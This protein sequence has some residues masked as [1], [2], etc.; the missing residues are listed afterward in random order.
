MPQM[1]S[2][3]S[4]MMQGFF[5]ILNSFTETVKKYGDC[6]YY[7]DKIARWDKSKLATQWFD[8]ATPMSSGFIVM[9]H[10][11]I[12]LNNMMYKFDAD[13]NPLDVSMIDFQVNFWASPANDIMYFLLSSVADDIKVDLFDELVEFYHKE[14]VAGLKKL[15]YDQHIP[16]LAELHIDL[17]DKG[18]FGS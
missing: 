6:D 4:P 15:S 12:W 10:G 9:N 1:M 7:A 16:T 14:L 2:E 3:D 13:G 17:L 8:V 5:R 11:D 18:S